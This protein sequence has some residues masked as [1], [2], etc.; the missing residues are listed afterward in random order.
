MV[1]NLTKQVDILAIIES[2]Q[3]FGY[4]VQQLCSGR[5]PT[6]PY[7]WPLLRLLTLTGLKSR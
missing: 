6:D 2:S 1:T 3:F 4:R 7:V 5:K